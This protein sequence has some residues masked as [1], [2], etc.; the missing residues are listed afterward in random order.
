MA[1]QQRTRACAR[2]HAAS[3]C[4]KSESRAA[5]RGRS[6]TGTADDKFKILAAK[7]PGHHAAAEDA[8]TVMRLPPLAAATSASPDRASP[9]ARL[10]QSLAAGACDSAGGSACA[11]A[12]ARLGSTT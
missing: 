2:A 7:L 11:D 3:T 5:E 1:H 12:R 6:T 10:A 9:T 4:S 8:P